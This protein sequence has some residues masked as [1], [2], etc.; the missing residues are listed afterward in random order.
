MGRERIRPTSRTRRLDPESGSV[1]LSLTGADASKFKLNDTIDTATAGSK[2][3]AFKDKPD[4]EMPGDSNRDNVYQV[5]VVASD[6]ANSAMRDVIVKVTDVA[7]SG[8]IKVAPEQPRVG[9]VLTA[10]LTDSDGVMSPTWKWR[11]AMATG[12]RA[13][14]GLLMLLG[15]RKM[16]LT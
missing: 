5:T 16:I 15:P 6:G 4:F 1:T 12:E 2:V 13:P 14:R 10:T 8:K 7:E 3:L 11:K 9:T